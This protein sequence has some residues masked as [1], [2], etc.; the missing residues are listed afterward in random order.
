MS[1]DPNTNARLFQWS[2][3][4]REQVTPQL[5]RQLVSG[6]RLMVARV[7]L[8][9]G[10]VIPAHEHV[11]EQITHVVAGHLRLIV[12]TDATETFELRDGDILHIPSNVRHAGEAL[13]DCQVFDFFSPPRED[14]L[15]G[16][17]SY[18]RPAR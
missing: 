1:V 10:C 16:T 12:G 7:S 4:P 5:S 3:V 18:L 17:D 9:K 13:E 11:H 15:N 6:E 8:E 14:W 2:A